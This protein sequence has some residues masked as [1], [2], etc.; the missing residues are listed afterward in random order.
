MSR[1]LVCLLLSLTLPGLAAAAM[2]PE[3]QARVAALAKQSDSL[4]KQRRKWE[5]VQQALLAQK[6]QIEADQAELGKRQEDLDRMSATHNQAAAAQQQRLKGGGCDKDK[7]GGEL[8][9]DQ[10]NKDAKQLNAG[11]KQLNA[12]S[13]SL[14]TEQAALE[15]KYAK[16]NQDASDW[17][18]HESQ[19]TEHLNQVYRG[20]NDW[21]DKAYGVITDSDFRDEVTAQGADAQCENKGLPAGTLPIATV[22]RLAD[23]YRK[24]LSYVLSAQQQGSKPA[25]GGSGP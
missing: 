13:A 4:Y 10:C 8:G 2:P 1:R 14:E 11:T 20:L 15:T 16:A 25:S 22:K 17:N 19:A 9:D 6:Q 12:E 24:C 23:G 18:A 3:L 21:L 5:G 7:G